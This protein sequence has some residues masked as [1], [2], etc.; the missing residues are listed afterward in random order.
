MARANQRLAGSVVGLGE[1]LIQR[2]TQREVSK[3][4]AEFAKAQAELTVEWKETLRKADPNDPSTADNFRRE[5]VQRRLD[6]LKGLAK[7]REA[8]DY[9]TRLSSGLGANFLEATEAG[10]DHLSEVAAVQSF[11][12]VKNQMSDAMS[13]DPLSFE[14][15]LPTV[16]T[17]IEGY[18][19]SYGLSREN[20]LKLATETREDL[21][22]SAARGRIDLDP[23]NGR[24][25][26]E[27]GG[28]SEY[29]SPAQKAQLLN[30]ADGLKSSQDAAFKR[31]REEAS[32]SA[33]VD[34]MQKIGTADFD[35]K[36]MTNDPRLAHDPDA[37]RALA[38]A[39]RAADEG[40]AGSTAM[41]DFNFQ[42][43]LGAVLRGEITDSRY[44]L[45]QVANGR[46]DMSRANS[47]LGVLTGNKT[48]EGELRN[49]AFSRFEKI[50][51]DKLVKGNPLAGKTDPLGRTRWAQF[52]MGLQQREEQ[53]RSTGKAGL[54]DPAVFQQELKLL[55]SYTP[56]GGDY[57]DEKR[58]QAAGMRLRT[59]APTID[60]PAAKFK[61]IEEYEASLRGE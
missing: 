57:I 15:T 44:I 17:M 60:V 56:A 36:A 3:L 59:S 25:F 2:Q 27:A 18:V 41:K 51:S 13:A 8:K 61:S 24:A 40:A 46:Y 28:Y 47:I 5:K 31:A 37:M 49:A 45:T 52:M 16:N 26:V 20:A 4:N 14:A 43:D 32:T 10:M 12:T 34:W 30:Y 35:F 42:N 7:T 58:A 53:R 11:Q 21:A 54:D 19:Q 38:S 9:Y 55:E 1:A 23:V 6:E 22:F 50:A 48:P 39:A 33:Q 29:L